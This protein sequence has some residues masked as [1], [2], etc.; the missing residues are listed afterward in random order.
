MNSKDNLDEILSRLQT[1]GGAS[2]ENLEI[3]CPS[4]LA[5]NDRAS[6]CSCATD[7]DVVTSHDSPDRHSDGPTDSCSRLPNEY[8]SEVNCVNG[9]SE[10]DDSHGLNSVRSCPREKAAIQKDLSLNSHPESCAEMEMETLSESSPEVGSGDCAGEVSLTKIR[11][12][13]PK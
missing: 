7:S 5:S 4:L 9:I 12:T 10:S 8:S 2:H 13:C 11:V 3:F 1:L 6:Y